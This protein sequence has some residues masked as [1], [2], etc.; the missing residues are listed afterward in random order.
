LVSCLINTDKYY[1]SFKIFLLILVIV[2]ESIEIRTTSIKDIND[3]MQIEPMSFG[4]S[5]WSRSTFINEINNINSQYLSA[6]IISLQKKDN[7]KIV[8]YIG[9]WKVLDEGHITTLAIHQDYRRRHVAD[10]LLYNLICNASLNSIKWLTL[11]VRVSN[12]AALN[13]YKKFKFKHLGIRKNYYQSDNEDAYV[14]WTEN[15]NNPEYL[16]YIKG[17]I[18]PFVNKTANTDKLQYTIPA[19][20]LK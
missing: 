15:I 1:Y 20:Q 18:S 12:I 17:I 2:M 14:L 3:I 19:K 11:E 7:S 6:E 5:H 10:I 8:G 9:Y 13:L 4:A 16:E